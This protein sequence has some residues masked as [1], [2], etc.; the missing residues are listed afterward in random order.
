MV[1][2]DGQSGGYWRLDTLYDDQLGVGILG[3]Q[4]HDFKFQYVGAVFRN[5]AD[6]ALGYGYS[7]YVGQGTGWVFIPPEDTTGSRTMPPFSGPGNGGW[8]TEGGP[9]LTLQGEDVHI[10]IY[11]TGTRPGSVLQVGDTFHFAGHIMPTLDSQV[12]Y[13]VT[14][15]GGT[16]Y[17]SAGQANSIGYFYLP[18]EDFVVDEPGIWSV[19]VHVWHDGNCSGGSTIPPYPSGDVLG[20][21]TGRYWFYVVDPAGPRLNVATPEPGYL[22]YDGEVTPILITGTVPASIENPLVDY[23]ISMPGFILAHG[24][25]A[26]NDGVYQITFDPTALHEDFPNLDLVGRDSHRP[27]LSD[28][29]SISL[30]LGGQR[31]GEDYFLANT[32]TIQGQQVYAWEGAV[33]IPTDIYLPVIEGAQ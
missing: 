28:T 15:P 1:A 13:T 2:E 7:E 25:V 23:T 18:G 4:P 24:Q 6:N 17:V 26:P 12:A 33:T 3:D 21:E 22:I 16:Q 11:P 5:F 29:F 8:T 14:A 27:G 19:D 32:I 10:F 31:L 20:G 30:L 9:I